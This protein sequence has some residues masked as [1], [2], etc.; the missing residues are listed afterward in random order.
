MRSFAGTGR[1]LVVGLAQWSDGRAADHGSLTGRL[2]P[3]LGSV[4][5]TAATHDRG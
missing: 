1:L 5:E 2:R 4:T 3:L